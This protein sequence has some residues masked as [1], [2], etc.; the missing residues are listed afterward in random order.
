MKHTAAL[1]S[2][3]F[4][5]FS[6]ITS[7]GQSGEKYSE[8]ILTPAPAASPKING[9][10]VYGMRA[11]SPLI[12]RIPCTGERPIKFEAENLPDGVFIDEQTGIL[13]GSVDNPGTYTI[14]LRAKNDSGSYAKEF[15]LKVG[16]KLAL[17]PPMG[18]NSWYIHYNRISE[19]TMRQAADQMIAT[20]M[21]D[22]GYQ[23][24][25]I[26]D[27]WMRKPGSEDPVLGGKCRDNNGVIIPNGRFPD[28]K[29]M[30]KYIHAKGLKAGTYI[31]PGPTTCAGYE[32]SYKHEALD[33]ETFAAWGFDFLKYD[34]CSYRKV[35]GSKSNPDYYIRPYRQMWGE[36]QKQGRDIVLN[37]CQ[38]GMGN[39]WEWG[40]QVG[41]CWRTTGD[42]GLEDRKNLPGFYT[43]GFSNAAHAEYAG[44]GGWND[45]DYILIGW[46]GNAHG[47]GEGKPTDLTPWEQYSYM[48]MWSL[49]AA[50]LIFSGDMAKLDRFTLNI[51]CNAEVIEVD[52]DPLGKQAVMIEKTDKLFIM[53][54]PMADGSLAVG[55]FNLL[56]KKQELSVSWKDLGIAGKKRVRDLWRQKDLGA[57]NNRFAVDV[58]PRGVSL[59]RLYSK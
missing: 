41:N 40:A 20:G 18:W 56:P 53:A 43:I 45:P 12:Y 17:T 11:G 57:Y 38:Y 27:C 3:L 8:Y 30:V 19:K 54:K 14:T 49:M 51:L 34:W 59:V 58:Q 6:W 37:L 21:A 24:V 36:L 22:F 10:V 2:F 48:S 39:V 7:P 52:Q 25:N 26:D 16:D 35:A 5:V 42:L 29:G 47:M 44:P 9:P 28:I 15:T 13:T 55:L 23:Y 33:A 46:V 1:F 50:P 4:F 32:G 31:S